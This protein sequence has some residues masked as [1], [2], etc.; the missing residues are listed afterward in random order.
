MKKILG[1][2]VV[3]TITGCAST[4][5]EEPAAPNASLAMTAD[6]KTVGE[7]LA[8]GGQQM[9]KEEIKKYVSGS[10]WTVINQK[11][12]PVSLSYASDGTFTGKV[13]TFT[14]TWP[15]HGTWFTEKDRNCSV[16]RSRGSQ[17]TGPSC[18]Y[19]YRLGHKVYTAEGTAPASV[20]RERI[21]LK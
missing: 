3:L 2:V 7:L 11:G 8:A 12:D 16:N 4:G 14:G 20:A 1:L 13:T 5:K 10:S 17:S 21:L 9:M 6:Q 18:A 19:Y 15:L